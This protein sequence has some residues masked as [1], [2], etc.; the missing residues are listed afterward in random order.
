VKVKEK[1]GGYFWSHVDE[2][3]VYGSFS[4]IPAETKSDVSEFFVDPINDFISKKKKSE[5]EMQKVILK[6]EDTDDPR[7]TEEDWEDLANQLYSNKNTYE[8]YPEN[9]LQTDCRYFLEIYNNTDWKLCLRNNLSVPKFDLSGELHP[10]TLGEGKIEKPEMISMYTFVNL[11][12]IVDGLN[13]YF[14]RS[15]KENLNLYPKMSAE[16]FPQPQATT[17]YFEKYKKENKD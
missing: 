16:T 11:K 10:Y 6:T 2:L 1:N 9:Y 5:E 14:E 17:D 7:M 8:C 15:G 12:R 4:E 3:H 13:F